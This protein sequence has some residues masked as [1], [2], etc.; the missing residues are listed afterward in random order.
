MLPRSMFFTLYGVYIR[1]FGEEIRMGSLIRLLAKDWR[2]GEAFDLF[3]RYD[4]LLAEGAGRYFY[5][6][7]TPDVSAALDEK[8]IRGLRAQ[9]DP[10]SVS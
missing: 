7:Y 6:L 1:H 8:A 5:R 9:L 4:G 3:R 10:F 2:G